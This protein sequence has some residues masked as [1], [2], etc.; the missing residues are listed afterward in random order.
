MV[1]TGDDERNTVLEEQPVKAI[2]SL[3]IPVEA[4]ME[5]DRKERFMEKHKL[6][7]EC[8]LQF[9]LQPGQLLP[10]YHAFLAGKFCI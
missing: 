10:L 8:S 7:T 1:V 6:V 2:P 5:D 9:R 3:L 4:M